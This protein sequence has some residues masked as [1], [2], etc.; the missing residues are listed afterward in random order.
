MDSAERLRFLKGSG[1]TIIMPSVRVKEVS[2]FIP[3]KQLILSSRWLR[4]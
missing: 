3:M 2:D 4:G 1:F